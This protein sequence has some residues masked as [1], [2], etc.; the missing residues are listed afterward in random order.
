M[1]AGM[2][3]RAFGFPASGQDV[4]VSVNFDVRDGVETWTRTFSGKSFSSVQ[5]EGRGASEHLLCERFGPLNFA[6]ALVYKEA[7]IHLVL[8]RW[9]AFGVPMPLWLGPQSTA[10]ESAIDEKFRFD[11]EIGHPMVGLIVRYRGWLDPVD[12]KSHTSTQ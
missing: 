11:V 4:E 3:A 9:T 5:S 7:Q 1:F 12:Q 6:M 8:R 10:H 2:I